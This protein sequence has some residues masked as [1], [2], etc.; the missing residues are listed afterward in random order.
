MK[1]KTQYV[2]QECGYVSPRWLGKCPDCEAWNSFTEEVKAPKKSKTGSMERTVY[3]KPKKISEIEDISLDRYST[4]NKEFDRVLGGG[5]VPGGLVLLGGDP[6]IG[7]STLLLESANKIAD[8]NNKVLYISGEESLQ[9]LKM[10][11][12]RM[13]VNSENLS[14]LS[15]INMDYIKETILQENPKVVIID[16]IQTMYSPDISSSPG[17]VSQIREN[18]NALMQIAKKDNITI[19]LVGHVTKDGNLA[20]PRVLEHMVDTVLYFEGERYHT[21]RILRAVKNRFG[22]TNEVGIFEMGEEGLEQVLNPSEAMLTSRPDNTCGS[23]VVPTIEGSRP[24]LIEL[25][26]L[27]SESSY[28]NSRRMAT[29]FDYNRMILLIAILE[30]RLGISLKEMDCYSNIVGGIRSDEPA[31]DLAVIA[32]LYSSYRDTEIP[33]DMIIFGEVGLTGEVRDVQNVEKRVKEAEKL[34]FKHCILPKGNMRS[35][36]SQKNRPD[37]QFYPVENISQA[38]S[39]LT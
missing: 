33:S 1:N 14:F 26:G 27:V 34:G 35:F 13:N 23:V 21:Y 19:I 30:K 9:Q 6:G 36:K 18:T 10:R 12:N 28:G 37:I 32:A 8:K 15:E 38:L 25:Q 2:C 11:A 29:G 31:L 4:S 20:G 17:S 22:A 5:L 3:S 16:S 39:I 7:K 24:L